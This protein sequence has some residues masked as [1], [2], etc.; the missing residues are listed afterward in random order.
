IPSRF[1]TARPPRRPISMASRGLT[2]PS[3]AAAITGIWKRCPQRSQEMSTSDGL[4]VMEPGTSAMSSNP[5][6]ARAFRPRPTHIPM[7]SSPLG[8]PAARP[9]RTPEIYRGPGRVIPYL[10]VEYTVPPTACQ[11][12]KRSPALSR[13]LPDHA[14]ALQPQIRVHHLDGARQLPHLRGEPAGADD[15]HVTAELATHALD[16]PVDEP[17]VAQHDAGLDFGGGIAPH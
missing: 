12:G 11:S 4:M 10:G 5:Y 7:L 8:R 6:A 16:E 3:M 2:T 9:T 13:V 14:Q 15:L 1:R 17:R